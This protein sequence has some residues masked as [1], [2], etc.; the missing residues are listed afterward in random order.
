MNIR[1]KNV[2]LVVMIS[3]IMAILR[4]VIVSANLEKNSGNADI[5]YLPENFVVIAFAVASA[6]LLLAFLVSAFKFGRKTIEPDDISTPSSIGSLIASFA[7]LGATIAYSF[8]FGESQKGP[9]FFANGMPQRDFV[10]LQQPSMLE[11][12]VVAFAVASALKFLLIGIRNHK[13]AKLRS[14]SVAVL[15]LFPIAFAALRLLNDFIAT[16]AIPFASSNAYHMVSLIA[17]LLFFLTEGKAY[18][19]ESKAF[20][21][22]FYGYTAIFML[23]VYSIPNLVLSSFGTLTFDIDAA[24]SIADIG[25]AVYVITKLYSSKTVEAE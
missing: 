20:L 25:F 1:K 23:S 14:S 17:L 19:S 10:N 4:T 22:D 11:I 12:F 15:S 21:P 6:I 16:S 3:V 5:Y 13:S 24:F 18:V 7:L 9:E 2:L 8:V